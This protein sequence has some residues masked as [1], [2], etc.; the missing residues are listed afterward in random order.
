[1]PAPRPRVRRP[2]DTPS[3]PARVSFWPAGSRPGELQKHSAHQPDPA[4]RASGDGQSDG[5]C[6][7]RV[8]VPADGAQR[9]EAAASSARPAQPGITCP[10][11]FRTRLGSPIPICIMS[12]S[13]IRHTIHDR[14]RSRTRGTAVEVLAAGDGMTRGEVDA[15]VGMLP[16]LPFSRSSAAEGRD[17]RTTAPYRRLRL[18]ASGTEARA[19]ECSRR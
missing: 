13:F 11:T 2:P 15:Q 19:Y 17:C 10:R 18:C 9:R 12:T 6:K 1:M 8:G 5:V 16:P 14:R 3:I 4:G 7:S